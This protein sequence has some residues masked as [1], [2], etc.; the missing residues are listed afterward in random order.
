ARHA[1]GMTQDDLALLRLLAASGA[2]APRRRLL[3]R[4]GSPA[5]AIEA[6]IAAW[7]DAGTDA[8]Q[9]RALEATRPSPHAR[10]W[11]AVPGQR[12]LC[13]D[14]RNYPALLRRMPALPLGL[15]VAGDTVLLWHPSVAVVGTRAPTVGGR[16]HAR[17]FGTALARSGLGVCSG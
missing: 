14:D 11:Q 17:G 8:A 7:R 10:D 12:L 16:D 1:A 13:W 3:E 15:I 2:A 4:Y 5:R 9:V 6:G